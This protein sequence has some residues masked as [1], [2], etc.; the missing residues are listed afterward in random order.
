VNF[1]SILDRNDGARKQVVESVNG[2]SG[3]TTAGGVGADA[4][5]APIS[6][7]TGIVDELDRLDTSALREGGQ[8]RSTLKT[9]M[10]DSIAADRHYQDWM[11]A[12]GAAGCRGSAPQN[13]DYA[14][15]NAS[16]EAATTSKKAF[17]TAWNPVAGR[18][19]LRQVREQDL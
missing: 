15:A 5:E 13:G 9:A 6:T 4:L 8:L 10:Q 16:S 1:S 7:R 17:V 14:A 19:G 12:V 11:R 2:V 18:F 3:C